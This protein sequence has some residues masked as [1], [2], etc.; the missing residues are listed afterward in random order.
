[1]TPSAGGLGVV[2]SERRRFIL[3]HPVARQRAQQAIGDAPVGHVVSISPPNKKREQEEKY[4]AMIGDI[5]EQCMH[6]GRTWDE[7]SW[8]RLLIDEFADQMRAAG[9]PLH[10]DGAGSV[11]PSLDGRRI[12]QLGI[13]SRRFWVAE[14]SAFIEFLYAYGAGQGVRWTQREEMPA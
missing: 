8:K 5:A 11:T 14:A 13:Q 9:T 6:V 12:V 10:H 4:H 1:L 7:E 3:A 2:M